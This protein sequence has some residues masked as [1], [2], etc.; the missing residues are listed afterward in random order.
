MGRGGRG[1]PLH[2][3]NSLSAEG[4]KDEVKQAWRVSSW[5]SGTRGPPRLPVYRY[6]CIWAHFCAPKLLWVTWVRVGRSALFW[7]PNNPCGRSARP[8][9]PPTDLLQLMK[10][11]MTNQLSG[12]QWGILGCRNKPQRK[13]NLSLTWSVLLVKVQMSTTFNHYPLSRMLW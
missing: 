8:R 1:S 12:F 6:K 9:S 11:R 3:S 5:R 7:H 13:S 2:G 4:T 10:E